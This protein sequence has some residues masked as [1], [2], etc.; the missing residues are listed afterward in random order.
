MFNHILTFSFIQHRG[1]S[2]EEQQ[3]RIK[4]Q[5]AHIERMLKE[6][7]ENPPSWLIVA[8]HYPVYSGGSNG[9]IAELSTY[10]LPLLIKYKVHA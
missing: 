5:L 4:D 1:I 7:T 2:T 10:L 3:R 8:G 6:A 9:D